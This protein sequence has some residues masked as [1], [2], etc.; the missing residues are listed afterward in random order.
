MLSLPIS[1]A[2]WAFGASSLLT[3]SAQIQQL[4]NPN[5]FMREFGV[6][7]ADVTRLVAFLL[8]ILN[9][10]DLVSVVTNNV[11]MLWVSIAA[12]TGAFG[13]FYSLG[14]KWRGLAKLE[15]GVVC[16]LAALL[17]LF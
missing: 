6:D 17:A 15:G 16:V 12:R 10:Y 9:T 11:L 2:G 14:G 8:I 5:G 4:I 13:L 1:V 7:S 3:I